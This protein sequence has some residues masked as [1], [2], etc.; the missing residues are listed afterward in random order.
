MKKKLITLLALSS[1]L[2]LG[3]SC[4][5]RNVPVAYDVTPGNHKGTRLGVNYGAEDIRI[6]TSK[7]TRCL[8]DRWYAETGYLAK[9]GNL[10]RVVIT[11][12][13]NRSDTYI[14][15]DMVRDI[16]ESVAINDGRYTV[17][18]GDTKDKQELAGLLYEVTHD[19]KYSSSSRPEAQQALAPQ[20]LGKVRIT[21]SSSPLPKYTVEE[22][23]LTITLY[24]IET[25]TALDSA[26][27]VL[28]K[29][30]Y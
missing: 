20:F 7:V 6:Q 15:T 2:S 22:Y 11:E 23:R 17:T 8:M 3:S 16:I 4:S 26:W 9:K 13:D 29:K 24:D 28:R 25:Q 1:A 21:K 18:V 27:D 5:T 10:P 19:P 30:V 12:I 14:S